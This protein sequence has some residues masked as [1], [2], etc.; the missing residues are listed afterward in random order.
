M[1]KFILSLI[2]LLSVWTYLPV[3]ADEIEDDYLDIV[4]DY[5][6]TGD[7]NSAMTYLEK[8]LSINPNNQHILDLKKTIIKLSHFYKLKNITYLFKNFNIFRDILF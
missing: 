3:M 5:C 2:L 7:Y 1:K 8:I 4:A 6:L